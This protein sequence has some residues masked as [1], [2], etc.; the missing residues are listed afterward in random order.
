MSQFSIH[1]DPNVLISLHFRSLVGGPIAGA[2]LQASNGSFAGMI[3]FS[4]STVSAGS[5]VILLSRIAIE[6]Q[7]L[8][9][10]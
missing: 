7:I 1:C 8:A 5:L 6:R 10:V 9:R 2:I 4:G 3:V